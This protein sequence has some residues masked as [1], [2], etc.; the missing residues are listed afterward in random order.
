M[1]EDKPKHLQIVGNTSE[2]AGA[3][4]GRAAIISRK[5]AGFCT[6]GTTAVSDLF[7]QSG[8]PTTGTTKQIKPAET[9]DSN[10]NV[11]EVANQ[12]NT[13]IGPMAVLKAKLV[14]TRRELVKTQNEAEKAKSDFISQLSAL[15]AEN[16]LLFSDL[17]RGR[18]E[19]RETKTRNDTLRARVVALESDLSK[20]RCELTETRSEAEKAQADLVSQLRTLQTEKESLISDLNVARSKA[21]EATLREDTVRA[22]IVTSESDLA[23]VRLELEKTLAKVNHREGNAESRLIEVCD[24]RTKPEIELSE[25]SEDKLALVPDESRIESITQTT[26][27]RGDKQANEE[28]EKQN[29][30][31]LIAEAEAL[32][33]PKVTPEEANSAVFVKP[34][35]KII[36]TRATSDLANTEVAVRIDAV[37]AIASIRHELSLKAIVAH[38]ADEPCARVRQECI[39]A[40]TTLE[41]KEAVP[42]LENALTDRDA[43]VR[44]AAVRSLYH[45]AGQQSAPVLTHMFSDESE[46]VRRRAASCIGWLG[47][48]EL[49]VELL[50]LLADSSVLVRRAAVEAMGNL[51]SRK[52]V[53]SLIERLNDPDESIRKAVLSS[54]K[55]ITGKKMNEPFPKNQ[56]SLNR[57][58]ARWNE[59]WKEQCPD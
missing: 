10:P 7:S 42:T 52:V 25:E 33:K 11:K 8:K 9:A 50:P 58:I 19:V 30:G 43:F 21:S 17:D 6:R 12:K 55:T 29:S 46:D 41:M 20:I 14:A 53:Q 27:V 2:H 24:I 54:L 34:E 15:E 56:K 31:P 13:L 39:K 38:M 51:R 3:F 48:K 44:L 23:A 57:L 37:N 47:K 32:I 18:S 49:A 35:E 16:E 22:R 26:A 36:F 45:L 40:L 4:V 59:W 28:T 1:E 5:I